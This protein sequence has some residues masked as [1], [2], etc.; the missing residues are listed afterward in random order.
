MGGVDRTYG[1]GDN[2]A[3]LTKRNINGLHTQRRGNDCRNATIR[4]RGCM[5]GAWVLKKRRI[6]QG[7]IQEHKLA[8][9]VVIQRG[10]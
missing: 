8:D 5:R 7:R 4:R 1:L 10:H 9:S 6:Y 2:I 3:A